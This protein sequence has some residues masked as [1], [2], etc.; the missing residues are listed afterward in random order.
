MLY[1]RFGFALSQ[2]A[3]CSWLT[4]ACHAQ[5]TFTNGPRRLL[6]AVTLGSD[7]GPAD[8]ACRH[9]LRCDDVPQQRLVTRLPGAAI[10]LRAPRR[11]GAPADAPGM[12]G[13]YA[14]LQLQ[15]HVAYG[16][17]AMMWRPAASDCWLGPASLTAADSP[18]G[19]GAGDLPAGEGVQGHALHCVH[20][21]DAA[22]A[23]REI[24]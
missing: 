16:D 1:N 13:P 11:G 5:V 9:Q 6:E 18:A 12:R 10:R 7:P 4:D 14:L 24:H 19:F 17:K 15:K 2:K 3:T 21:E 20:A 23:E 22:V 8:A